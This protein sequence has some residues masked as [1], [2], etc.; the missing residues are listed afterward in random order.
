MSIEQ[1]MPN[2]VELL[3]E[4]VSPAEALRFYEEN[5]LGRTIN[6]PDGEK[7]TL[8]IGHFF[9]LVCDGSH[10]RK[11]LVVGFDSSKSAL[12]AI[13]RNE[14][15]PEAINGYQSDRAR[16]LP[17]FIDTVEHP[18]FEMQEKDE[19]NKTQFVKRYDAE[20]GRG[21][22]AAFRFIK[23]GKKIQ[24]FHG[25]STRY[26]KVKKYR[27]TYVD[28]AVIR[29]ASP[30][31]PELINQQAINNISYFLPENNGP[32]AELLEAM[33]VEKA[34]SVL[35]PKGSTNQAESPALPSTPH[36]IPHHGPS[37]QGGAQRFSIGGLYTGSAAD[38]EKPSLHYV[39]TGEG[40]QV[41]GWGLYASNERGVAE[42]Y[43]TITAQKSHKVLLDGKDTKN[44]INDDPSL[45]VS[46][47]IWDARNEVYDYG[48]KE[49][50]IAKVEKRIATYDR[51]LLEHPDLDDANKED[52]KRR[53]KKLRD[54][55]EAI[56]NNNWEFVKGTAN[57]YKQTFFT[58]RAP[59]DEVP[60]VDV[61]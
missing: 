5:I 60:P 46:S 34:G 13:R 20:G 40:T 36:I 18:V 17:V 30:D 10:G 53:I 52:Y 41:Y 54:S 44:L 27:I 28:D 6:M 22:V 8:D 43:A 56:K 31:A 37:A 4:D 21:V 16:M 15:S 32:F 35:A 29:G 19:P 12:D 9:R 7:L 58:N 1:P 2:G 38:Y 3:P 45:N 14:V 42:T 11:G 55:L 49:Q 61:G 26:G 50:A 51:I 48:G 33:E 57:I 24:S 47:A 59:R 25:F 39:G 23:D